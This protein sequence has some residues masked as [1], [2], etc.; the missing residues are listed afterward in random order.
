MMKRADHP[1]LRLRLSWGSAARIAADEAPVRGHL[2]RAVVV[3][4]PVISYCGH[5]TSPSA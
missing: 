2:L 5:T 4:M 1:V 3:A